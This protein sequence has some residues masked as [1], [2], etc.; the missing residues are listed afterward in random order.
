MRLFTYLESLA[1]R[2]PEPA[3]E[4]PEC[5]KTILCECNRR[6]CIG[7]TVNTSYYVRKIRES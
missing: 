2:I 4:R 6:S 1:D 7:R 5:G 3:T